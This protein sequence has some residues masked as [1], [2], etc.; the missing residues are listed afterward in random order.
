MRDRPRTTMSQYSTN[1]LLVPIPEYPLLECAPNKI[2][3]L[4][5]LG[6]SGVG[7]TALIVRFLTKRFIGDY[8][9]NT[10]TS[11][12]C[13]ADSDGNKRRCVCLAPEGW[14]GEWAEGWAARR[15]REE[16][17]SESRGTWGVPF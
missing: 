1:F 4:V 9:A 12:S 15:A 11:H 16:K 3:K 17:R 5:V 8:E 10:G 13:L 14:K 7:K 6:G 2:I